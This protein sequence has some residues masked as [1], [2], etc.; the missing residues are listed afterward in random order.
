M[1]FLVIGVMMLLSPMQAMAQGPNP[2]TGEGATILRFTTE[3]QARVR[4]DR[5]NIS[6]GVVASAPTAGAALAQSAENMNSILKA[7]KKAKVDPRDI[8][9]SNLTLLPQFNYPEGGSPKLTGY[10]VQN[11]LDVTVQDL[12]TL[13][14]LIDAVTSSGANQLNG[15]TF[16]AKDPAIAVDNARQEAIAVAR[17]RAELYASALGLR[18]ARV[19]LVEETPGAALPVPAPTARLL[20]DAQANTPIEPGELGYGIAITITFELR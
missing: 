18:L 9:T 12:K 6:A 5:A 10:L 4:P 3:A 2:G 1:R 13:G 14:R 19:A 7:L 8:Q 11:T 16:S 20:G 17:K 15:V